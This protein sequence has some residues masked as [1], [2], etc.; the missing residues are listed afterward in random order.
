MRED[1]NVGSGEGEGEVSS[2]AEEEIVDEIPG[3]DGGHSPEDEGSLAS[4][5]SSS[6]MK[7]ELVKNMF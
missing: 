4:A 5:E 6:D 7:G 2:A 3:G 1:K